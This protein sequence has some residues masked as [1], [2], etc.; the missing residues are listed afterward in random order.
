MAN[1][2]L[3]TGTA[4]F[5]GRYVVRHFSELGWSVIGIDNS[6]PENAPLAS[7]AAYYTLRLPDPLLNEVVQKH[8]PIVCIHCAGRAAPGLSMLEPTPDFYANTVVTADIS[9]LEELGFTTSVTLER[10]IKT[11]ANWCLAELVGV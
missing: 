1:N 3:V 10:G 5:I 6:A 11:F 4:G 9:K 2:I 8:K 7:L